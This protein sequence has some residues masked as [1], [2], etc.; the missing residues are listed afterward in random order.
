MSG[1]DLGYAAT[2]RFTTAA[3]LRTDRNGSEDCTRYN[4]P[5]VYQPTRWLCSARTAAFFVF[6]FGTDLVRG[7]A[8]QFRPAKATGSGVTSRFLSSA[9]EPGSSIA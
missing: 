9:A 2:R 8:V 3:G 4:N 5:H 6:D 1:T 7:T